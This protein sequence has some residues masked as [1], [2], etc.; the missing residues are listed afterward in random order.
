MAFKPVNL[1]PGVGKREY[2]CEPDAPFQAGDLLVRDVVRARI[3]TA[4]STSNVFMIEAIATKTETT[5]A[6][7][8]RITALPIG[9]VAGGYVI[10]DTNA[11]TGDPQLNISHALTSSLLVDNTSTHI[12]TSA[13]IFTAISAVGTPGTRKL[14]GY[15]NRVPQGNY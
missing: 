12:S 15:L 9:A 13:A 8:V 11:N 2:I 4:S 1:I 10:A 7:T 14:F 6:G 3:T 5:G